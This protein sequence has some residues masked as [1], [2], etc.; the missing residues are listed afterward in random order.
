MERQ[1]PVAAL[2]PAWL[3]FSILALT[4]A[5]APGSAVPFRP[6]VL[7]QV[8]TEGRLPEMVRVEQSAR[9]AGL[10]RPA[11]TAAGWVRGLAGPDADGQRA[12]P[13]RAAIV[14]LVD[15]SD[16]P[17]DQGAYPP[18]HYDDMLFSVGSYPQGSMRDWYLENSYGQFHVTGTV[19]VWLRLPQT[20]AYYVDGQAGFGSYPRNAQKMAEDAVVA[21]DPFVDFRQFDN[22]GPDGVPDSGDDD[23]YVDALFVVHA[24]PGREETGSNNDIHSHAWNM[25]N[26]QQVDGV[27]ASSYSMEPD[28]GKRGV[29]GHEFGHVIGLPDLYDTDYSSSGV[30]DWCMM[31]FGSWGGGGLTPVHFLS[32]CK[33]QL[34]FLELTEPRTNVTAADLPQVETSPV[35]WSLWTGGYPERQ[36]FTVENRQRVLSDV[37]LPGSGLIICHVDENV[38]DN[39]NEDHPLVAIEQADGLNELADGGGSD[40]GDP[41]PGSTNNRNFTAASNPSSRDYN[42]NPS[43][44]AVRSISDSGPS[45]QADLDVENAPILVMQ[46]YEILE[47]SGN[48]D[49]NIDPGET[50]DMPVILY[51]R[52][53]PA[54]QVV[55]ALSS[56]DP[57]VTIL[58]GLSTYGTIG[59][60]SAGQGSPA[61]RVLLSESSTDDGLP[62]NIS[63]TAFGVAPQAIPLIVGVNDDLDT[64]RWQH[65]NV[66]AGYGDQWHISTRRNHSPGGSYSW[67]CGNV[68]NGN[69][70]NRLDAALTTVPVSL[71][72]VR[73]ITFWHWIQAEDDANFTAWDGGILEVSVD[74]GPWQDVGLGPDAG[75]DSWRQW[76]WRWDAAPGEHVLRCR[77]VDAA[78]RPQSEERL[79]PFP[80]GVSG[81]HAIRVT[82][83]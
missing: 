44:V 76:L 26:P 57:D 30:G 58:N 81:L 2:W 60:E 9:E 50:W 68:G 53:A 45:M 13:D 20:Y 42:G 10:D 3:V 4:L 36:Y 28:N 69:H 80:S 34:G 6:D 33:A 52:G 65:D 74:D 41:W 70:A 59:A 62:F 8:R 46:S 19:T 78:G 39:S 7:E 66:T 73:A 32:W 61:F 16:N 55:A 54:T 49:G 40:N 31:S 23:G 48:G 64:Y 75:L 5:P 11:P 43:Q 21:A 56:T 24:G 25:A 18:S 1:R 82:V 51:N 15:F 79:P 38:S 71:S 29:F 63:V 37:S 17:A 77:V 72:S 67:K 47:V 83:R 14:I 35:A 12:I 22:D 27:I